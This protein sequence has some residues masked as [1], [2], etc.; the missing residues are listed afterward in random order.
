MNL[1]FLKNLPWDTQQNPISPAQ[2]E[3]CF[4]QIHEL[5]AKTPMENMEFH[6]RSAFWLLSEGHQ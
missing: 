3:M 6:C 5:E 1:H 4:A 2:N